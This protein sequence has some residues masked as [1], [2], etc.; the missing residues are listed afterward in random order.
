MKENER[1]EAVGKIRSNISK[2][3]NPEIIYENIKSKMHVA[4]SHMAKMYKNNLRTQIYFHFY[5]KIHRYWS[6][7][8]TGAQSLS[9]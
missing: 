6:Y 3:K 1:I 4:K 8:V 7:V 9:K 2:Q 5:L